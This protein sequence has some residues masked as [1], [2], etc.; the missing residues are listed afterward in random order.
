ME[1]KKLKRLKKFVSVMYVLD[2]IACLGADVATVTAA[3]KGLVM[4]A[5]GCFVVAA[6]NG[7]AVWLLNL[8]NEAIDDVL[9]ERQEQP[10]N[11]IIALFPAKALYDMEA[12]EAE[13]A[14]T[15]AD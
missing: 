4:P 9:E 7:V 12:Y 14:R 10:K 15:E 11:N 2:M 6:L 13:R 8:L 5:V 1:T 3:Y